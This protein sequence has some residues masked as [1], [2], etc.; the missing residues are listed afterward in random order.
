[1]KMKT[2]VDAA[3]AL[4]KLA[5]AD[6]RIKTAY[7]VKKMVDV[8]EPE[9][10]YF[11]KTRAGIIDKYSEETGNGKVIKDEFRQKCLDEIKE[12]LDVDVKAE[13]TPVTISEDEDGLKLS[14]SDLELLTDLIKIDVKEN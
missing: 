3:P 9:L 8:I 4:R 5:S 1:M 6:L 13:I 11:D 7:V 14:V 2:L 12:L 10:Q